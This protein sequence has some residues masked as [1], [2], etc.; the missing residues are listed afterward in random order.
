MNQL[1]F[2]NALGFCKWHELHVNRKQLLATRSRNFAE[3]PTYYIEFVLDG[4]TLW[5]VGTNTIQYF[6]FFIPASSGTRKL[7]IKHVMQNV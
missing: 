4:R 3:K 5:L 6:E 7:I 1:S 2:K